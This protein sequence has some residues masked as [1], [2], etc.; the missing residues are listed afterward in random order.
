MSLV[1]GVAVQTPMRSFV[2]WIYIMIRQPYRVG[3]R[4]QIGDAIGDV[5]DVGYLATKH[6][7]ADASWAFP[8]SWWSRK[9]S[10]I[11]PGR[12]FPTSGARSDFP[13][14]TTPIFSSWKKPYSASSRKRS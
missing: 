9:P 5:I 12:C 3:D 8:I 2:G 14:R 13:S 10:L 1:V 7:R 4:I 11:I 6:L